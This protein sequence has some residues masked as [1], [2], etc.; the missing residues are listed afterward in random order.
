MIR[1][2][3]ARR[4]LAP[5]FLGTSIACMLAASA[6]RAEPPP[7]CAATCTALRTAAAAVCASLGGGVDEAK[8]TC[9]VDASGVGGG[10]GPCMKG[11]KPVGGVGGVVRTSCTPP[12]PKLAWSSWLGH[13]DP[14]G[15]GDFELLSDF[16]PTQL[17]CER[18]TQIEART[19]GGTAAKD[20][21]QL[22]ALHPAVGLVCKNAAQSGGT[23]CL[24][25]QVRFGCEPA[26][27]EWTHLTQAWHEDASKSG[28]GVLHFVPTSVPLPTARFRAAMTFSAPNVLQVLRLAPNDQHYFVKGIWSR[29]G[30]VLAVQ[31]QDRGETMIER[32]DV[33]ELGPGVL[34][35]KR[36]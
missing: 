31:Y 14:S 25:Y 6:A 36:Q 28:G 8:F 13:D 33:L 21:G 7:L 32:Y 26:P 24:D 19:S 9:A 17:G 35:L 30:N 29:T 11:D 15:E 5:R 4:W 2:A 22:I 23:S 1:I 18:P 16:T 34:K 10:G 3:R 27:V 20:T 12:A